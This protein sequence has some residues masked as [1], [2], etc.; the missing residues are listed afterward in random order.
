[1]EKLFCHHEAKYIAEV[2]DQT[3]EVDGQQLFYMVGKS[4]AFSGRGTRYRGQET[5]IKPN[6]GES[7]K[8]ITTI[9][10]YSCKSR[11]QLHHK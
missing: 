1:M 10:E 11:I 7:D 8:K 3:V 6:K 2:A 4:K 9:Y 5:L